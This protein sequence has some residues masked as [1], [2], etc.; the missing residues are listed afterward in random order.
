MNTLNLILLLFSMLIFLFYNLYYMVDLK[1]GVLK[2]I[3]DSIYHLP[4]NE[5]YLFTFFQWG[6]AIPLMIVGNTPL[7]FFSGAFICF[8]GVANGLARWELEDAIHVV[9]ATGGIALGGA[10]MWIDLKMWYVTV[11]LILFTLYTTS[12]WNKIS[13]HTTW[14]E[15]LAYFLFWGCLLYKKVLVLI[16]L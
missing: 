3:S 7:M 14:I 15:V 6:L 12:K 9:G 10:S 4:K 1:L 16:I 13:N 5:T 11:I 2:S 8:V